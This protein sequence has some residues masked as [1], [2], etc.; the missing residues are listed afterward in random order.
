MKDMG[1]MLYSIGNYYLCEITDDA[2]G[3]ICKSKY[4]RREDFLKHWGVYFTKESLIDLYK[5]KYIS[6]KGED[7]NTYSFKYV[8]N[9]R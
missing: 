6:M 5:G 7:G 9:L 1:Y 3:F 4:E 2:G 8:G